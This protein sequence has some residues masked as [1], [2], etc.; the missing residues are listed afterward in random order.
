M[1][2]GVFRGYSGQLPAYTYNKDSGNTLV[3]ANVTTIKATELMPKLLQS[4]SPATKSRSVKEPLLQQQKHVSRKFFLNQ[5]RHKGR[6]HLVLHEN[7]KNYSKTVLI[8]SRGQVNH[9][10]SCSNDNFC[11]SLS[12]QYSGNETYM[13]LVYSG[14]FGVG[15]DRY[16][17]AK[18]VCAI[19]WCKSPEYKTCVHSEL[20]FAE[21]TNFGPFNITSSSFK[22][23]TIYVSGIHQDFSLISNAHVSFNAKNSFATMKLNNPET[24]LMVAGLYGRWYCEDGF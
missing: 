15:S 17:L 3:V 22:A 4:P 10:T 7:L 14:K 5:S 24:N 6:K 11:C 20:G 16:K 23:E 12:Y 18:Q 19:V 8:S 13:F 21:G 2:S 9:L 1:G